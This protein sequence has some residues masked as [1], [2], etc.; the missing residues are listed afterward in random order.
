MGYSFLIPIAPTKLSYA[1]WT[2][3]ANL[4]S[5]LF[6][7]CATREENPLNSKELEEK[8]ITE[9][10]KQLLVENLGELPNNCKQDYAS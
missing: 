7:Y 3:D 4:L 8:I 10:G 2:M 5:I 1:S 9:T 6:E